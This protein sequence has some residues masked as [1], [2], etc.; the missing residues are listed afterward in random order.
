MDVWGVHGVGGVLG[1]IMLGVF[2]TKAV[3]PAVATEGLAFGST[4][5]FFKE[6]VTVLGAAAY[7]FVFTYIM[8]ALINRFVRVRVP[9]TEEKIGLDLA[10]HG[11]RAY[12][13]LDSLAAAPA[14]MENRSN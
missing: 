11:E 14:I 9:E 6:T 4:S 5:F 12:D 8:L 13:N 2:A 7:A 10:E 3:N 1:T